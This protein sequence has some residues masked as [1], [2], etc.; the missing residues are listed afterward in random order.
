MAEQH[1]SMKMGTKDWTAAKL[2]ECLSDNLPL[3][4]EQRAILVTLVVERARDAERLDYIASNARCDPK[5]DGQHVWWPTS[6]NH[7]LTGPTLR[8]AVDAA[9]KAHG[10]GA[11]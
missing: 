5:M 8:D 2:V 9:M 4:D 11:A 6:F 1:R 7:R 10:A 3:T